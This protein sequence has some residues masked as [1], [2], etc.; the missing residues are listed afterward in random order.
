MLFLGGACLVPVFSPF[1]LDITEGDM[2]FPL[3]PPSI[4]RWREHYFFFFGFPLSSCFMMVDLSIF[5]F[6]VLRD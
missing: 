4:R 6:I 3:A 2:C 5:Y 1:H